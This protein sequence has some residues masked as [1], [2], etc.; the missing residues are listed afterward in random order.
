MASELHVDSIKHSGGTSALTIDSSG[1]VTQ[2]QVPCFHVYNDD[3][4]F[5][6]TSVSKYTVNVAVVNNGSSHYAFTG[7]GGLSSSDDPTIYLARGQ[8]YQFVNN[9]GGSHPFQI[10]Q[11]AGG[12]AYTTGVT[13]AGGG[14]SASAGVIRF[15]VPFAAP[16]TLV[17]QCTSHG[18]MVGNIVVY[19]SI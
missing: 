14:S 9:S 13:Y 17:Y 4:N 6:N 3:T 2:P 8:T 18:S 10:R 15:E 16:N 12:S 1:R 19:P 5:S 7:D 11:S